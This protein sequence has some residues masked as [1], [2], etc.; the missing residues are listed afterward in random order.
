M[1]NNLDCLVT[2]A[3]DSR[4]CS[5][6]LE[7][8]GRGRAVEDSDVILEALANELKMLVDSFQYDRIL[9]LLEKKVDTTVE[10]S[11]GER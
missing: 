7:E 2:K 10:D 8:W 9:T 5:L 3:S 1:H 11:G 6:P 4:Y